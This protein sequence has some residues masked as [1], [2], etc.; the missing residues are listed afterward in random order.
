M[1]ECSKSVSAA[2]FESNE[3][4][5]NFIQNYKKTLHIWYGI[6]KL[7]RD[8][9]SENRRPGFQARFEFRVKDPDSLRNKLIKRNEKKLQS[10]GGRGY[11]NEEE[12]WEDIYD[13]AGVRILL[14][15]SA[16]PQLNAVE[17]TITST[18]KEAQKPKQFPAPEDDTDNRATPVRR[19]PKY[20]ATHYRVYLKRNHVKQL[21][22]SGLKL[23]TDTIWGNMFMIEIQV[24]SI[25]QHVYAEVSHDI[26]YKTMSGTPSAHEAAVFNTL[27]GVCMLG[28]TALEQLHFLYDERMKSTNQPF[29]NKYELGSFLSKWILQ[30]VAATQLALG[31]ME[32]LRR[33]LVACHKATPKDLED[34]LKKLAFGAEAR[35]ETADSRV[36]IYIMEQMFKD[37]DFTSTIKAGGNAELQGN[38]MASAM[39]WLDELFSP[40]TKWAL[41]LFKEEGPRTTSLKETLKWLMEES[42]G[43]HFLVHGETLVEIEVRNLNELWQWFQQH[44]SPAVQFVVKMSKVEHLRRDLKKERD[45]VQK[46]AWLLSEMYPGSSRF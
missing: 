17:E 6:T 13:R 37:N 28:D 7:A 26:L 27:S 12:I 3:L 24:V 41:K 25:F 8:L 1:A 31:P 9:C 18:F 16:Q 38:I 32:V 36:S 22:E 10:P 42:E 29:T 35:G 11:Q 2:A 15:T 39:I 20:T 30:N 14:Y 43:W 4:I 44:Q 46:I 40:S 33:F 19:F 45:V 5:E 21:E 23:D 34:I